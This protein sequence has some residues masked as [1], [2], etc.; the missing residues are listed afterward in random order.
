MRPRVLSTF[1]N[2]FIVI[3]AISTPRP[4]L[5]FMGGTIEN[6]VLAWTSVGHD[7]N[8]SVYLPEGY[9]NTEEPYRL[10]IFLHGAAG[11]TPA[12]SINIM[13][14]VLDDLIGSQTIDPMIVV[15]PFVVW[16]G[17]D[18]NNY[19]NMHQYTNSERNGKYQDVITVDLVNW[20]EQIF[21]RSFPP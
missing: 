10:L 13:R 7:V 1:F 17:I 5:A 11:D 15:W 6:G 18:G 19:I 9:T 2:F 12:R 21:H 3:A 8:V 14:P 16:P 4:V 20:L